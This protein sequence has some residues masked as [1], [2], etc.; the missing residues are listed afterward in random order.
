MKD[1][2]RLPDGVRPE[3][4]EI[5]FDIDLKKFRFSGKETVSVTIDKPT[6]S[7]TLNSKGLRI[8]SAF[9]VFGNETMPAKVSENRKLDQLILNFGKKISRK[10]AL[11]IEFEG[12]L[13]DDLVGLYR[14]RYMDKGKEK[15]L[16]TTQFEAPY[17][18]RAF[19]CFDEPEFK[20]VLDIVK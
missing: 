5:A 10:A 2:I 12:G 20:A 17:A 19:P 1:K 3:N 6:K 15:Y 18:R 14:S 4:Y 9:A 11:T 8:K 13:T 7:I 16:A